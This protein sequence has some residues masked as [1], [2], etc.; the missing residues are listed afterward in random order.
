MSS[1]LVLSLTAKIIEEHNTQ[2][3]DEQPNENDE[4]EQK[5]KQKEKDNILDH[6]DEENEDFD[7]I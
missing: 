3:D 1:N 6:E 4:F 2:Q 7:Q 5:I